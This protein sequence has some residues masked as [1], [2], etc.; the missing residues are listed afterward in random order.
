MI[1]FMRCCSSLGWCGT[2]SAFCP[3]QAEYSNNANVCLPSPPR[4]PPSPRPPPRPPAAPAP[5]GYHLVTS[6]DG[7]TSA[8]EDATVARIMLAPGRYDFARSM[9]GC[10]YQGTPLSAVCITR[11]VTIAAQAMGT[12]VLNAHGSESSPRLVLTVDCTACQVELVGLN[13]TGGYNSQQQVQPASLGRR[14]SLSPSSALERGRR[15]L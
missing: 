4:P 15:K 11:S 2:S 10:N 8:L 3:G 1:C 14:C 12:A 5:P 7:L 13:L 9:S 6:V